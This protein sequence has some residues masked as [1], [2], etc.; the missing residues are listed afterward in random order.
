MVSMKILF[1]ELCVDELDRNEELTREKKRRW[2]KWGKNLEAAK[3][4]SVARCL[5]GIGVDI[6]SCSVHGFANASAKAYCAVVY[7]ACESSWSIE[8]RLLTSKTRVA[9]LKA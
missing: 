3:E 6:V 7:C 2:M 5:Y 9:S 8:V 4:I 1:Q